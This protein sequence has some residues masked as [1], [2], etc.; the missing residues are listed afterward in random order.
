MTK[1]EIVTMLK[2]LDPNLTEDS[3]SFA[4]ALILLAATEVG[5]DAERVASFTGLP[6]E[7]VARREAHLRA[8][9]VWDGEMV[10][11]SDWFDEDGG[12]GFWMD[13]LVGEGMLAVT[14]T[15]EGADGDFELH[16]EG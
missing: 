7:E 8:N 4:G 11:H 9:G 5:A 15:T 3:P 16:D 1:D 2:E 13:V 14:R 10:I 6:L 12:F